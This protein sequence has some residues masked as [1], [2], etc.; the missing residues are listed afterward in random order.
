ML[1]RP[2]AHSGQHV[3][4]T[5]HLCTAMLIKLLPGQFFECAGCMGA[6]AMKDGRDRSEMMGDIL[7][8]ARHGV[9]VSDVHGP[10]VVRNTHLRESAASVEN[11]LILC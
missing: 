11:V 1:Q 6:C 2:G 5:G 10:V 3:A 8:H 4:E 9:V 7:N